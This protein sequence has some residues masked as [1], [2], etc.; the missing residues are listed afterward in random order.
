M[1]PGSVKQ[2]CKLAL[3]GTGKLRLIVNLRVEF[4]RHIPEQAERALSASVILD[5]RRHDTAP[6]SDADHLT[7]PLCGIFHEVNDELR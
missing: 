5:A 4:A 6:A 1:Q 3:A 7:E 2:P